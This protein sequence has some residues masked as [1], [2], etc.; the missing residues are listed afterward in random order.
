MKA[1]SRSLQLGYAWRDGRLGGA[2]K[3]LTWAACGFVALFG[4]VQLGTYPV[5]MVG[6]PGE[7]ISN[8]TPPKITLL[9]LAVLQGG[10]L[11]SLQT[12]L[13]RWLE[14]LVPWTATVLVN[15]MI[16]TIYLW[17]LTAMVLVISLS[18]ALGGVGLG[19]EPG[20]SSWWSTR[21][22]WLGVLVLALIPFVLAMSRFERPK[23]KSESAVAPSWRLVLGSAVVCLGLALLALDGVAGDGWLGLRSWVLTLPFLGAALTRTWMKVPQPEESTPNG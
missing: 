11:L 20:T 8:T 10:F 13:R 23:A 12:P 21:P 18:A 3:T 2:A 7:G 4:L 9:A 1:C 22:L 19:L 6:V 14:R 15:G 16:M 17:H 5:S